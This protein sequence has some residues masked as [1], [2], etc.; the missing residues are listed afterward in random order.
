MQPTNYQKLLDNIFGI[1]SG[2]TTCFSIFD[3]LGQSSRELTHSAFIAQMLNPRGN[4]GMG[5]TF[6]NLF[7]EQLKLNEKFN[8]DNVEVE[9]EKDFGPKEGSGVYAKGGRVDIYIKNSH[10]QIIVIENK[11]YAN[12]QEDQLQ[13]Y[14]NS[15]GPDSFIYYLSLDRHAPSNSPSSIGYN[16]ISYRDEIKCWLNKCLDTVHL[17]NHLS[18]IIQQY[19]FTIDNLTSDQEVSNTIQSSS[20]NIR[21]A[22]QIARLADKARK[23]LKHRFLEELANH[24]SLNKEHIHEDGKEIVLSDCGCDWCVEYNVFIRFKKINERLRQYINK[25]WQQ[26]EHQSCTEKNWIYIKLHGDK[27]NLHDFNANA[28]AWLDKD[29][30]FWTD[31][32]A[33]IKEIRSFLKNE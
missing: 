21:A 19:M 10:G 23:N 20:S 25:W 16:L 9:I 1:I 18:T 6:L 33:V 30:A 24:L 5:T 11:L 14:R 12:D 17:N 22:L 29:N 31:L 26:N 27:I 8:T 4:H 3:M 28:S 15:T 7:L 32:D 2:H 13:R